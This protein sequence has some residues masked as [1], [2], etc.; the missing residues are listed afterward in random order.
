MFNNTNSVDLLGKSA[1]FRGECEFCTY[2]NHITRIRVDP[3]KTTPDWVVYHLIRLWRMGYFRQIAIRHVGQAGIR[4]SDLLKLKLPLPPLEEQKKIAEILRTI[5]DAIEI[6]RQKKE[7]LERMKKAV[8]EKLL[9][10]EV[11]I[12]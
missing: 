3:N 7:K 8:M 4:K 12:K 9:T 6:K 2:S 1:V 11:R 10:G 5:D